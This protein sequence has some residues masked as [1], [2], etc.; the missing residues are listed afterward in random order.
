MKTPTSTSKIFARLFD[1]NAP[2][3]FIIG[4]IFLQ[5]L[6]N[7]VYDLLIDW[8]GDTPQVRVLLVSLSLLGLFSVVA[9][10]WVW[11]KMR[12]RIYPD[13]P[14]DHQAQPHHGLILLTSPNP[15]AA[16]NDIIA[17]HRTGGILSHC[18]LI[19]TEHVQGSGKADD[20]V[21]RLNE[22]NVHAHT[23][24]VKDANQ[25]YMT[26]DAVCEAINQA[27]G[28]FGYTDMVIV[29]IT[30]GNK[31]MTAGAVM[32]CRDNKVSMEYMVTM[33]DEKG[34]VESDAEPVP[35]K[36]RLG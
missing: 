18:W 4:A 26:Y 30:G 5:L 36:V 32:A 13:I 21:F 15:K 14:P 20:L 3:F 12:P 17:H 24:L 34:N 29:D 16:D 22:Q 33:R 31:P 19:I 9:G 27:R 8:L 11:W 23:L 35:M 6:S 2:I 7:G 25:S 10:F 1:P 28:V